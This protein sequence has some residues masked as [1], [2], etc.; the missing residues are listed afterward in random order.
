[1]VATGLSK[2]LFATSGNWRAHRTRMREL[3]RGDWAA[4][5]VRE[6]IVADGRR[7]PVGAA[8]T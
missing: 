6:A 3:T 7:G 2:A 1:V 4:E 8:A 5:A